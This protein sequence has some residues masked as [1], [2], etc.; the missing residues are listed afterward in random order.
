MGIPQLV[1]NV[2][3]N[4]SINNVK[5]KIEA[6]NSSPAHQIRLTFNGQELEDKKLLVDYNI[7]KN[8]TLYYVLKPDEN[9]LLKIF[10]K[11]LTAGN[12]N[13][14]LTLDVR[15]SDSVLSLKRKIYAKTAIPINLQRLIVNGRQL[16][17]DDTAL[18]KY[19]VL[20]HSIIFIAQKGLHKKPPIAPK[21]TMTM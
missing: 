5:Q 14:T 18:S 1:L 10:V 12:S 15:S 16:D 2:S 13:M 9:P 17:N 19:N 11:S 21:T 3:K 7:E 6:K 4:D 8:S 20:M